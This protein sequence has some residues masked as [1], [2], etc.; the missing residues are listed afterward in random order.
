MIMFFQQRWRKDFGNLE[1]CHV[2]PMSQCK[3]HSVYFV[4]MCAMFRRL[5]TSIVSGLRWQMT[6]Y[7]TLLLL[8]LLALAEA[9]AP[10]CKISEFTCTNG[11]CV[12][13]NRYCNVANDCGDSSDEPRYCTREYTIFNF[14]RIRSEIFSI[15]QTQKTSIQ[16]VL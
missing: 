15:K 14:P 9:G 4:C 11:R 12:P 16:T 3:T 13:L 5:I 2:T 10:K 6:S 7:A 1:H 8:L